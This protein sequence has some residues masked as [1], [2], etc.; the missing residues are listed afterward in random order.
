MV[1]TM[2]IMEKRNITISGLVGDIEKGK[3]GYTA[4]IMVDDG[5]TY[6]ATVSIPNLRKNAYK[7]RRFSRGERI[8]ITGRS[9]KLGAELRITVF[10]IH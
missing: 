8:S 1:L 2:I 5:Q 4:S 3:D 9:F 7:Y 10:D 6:L